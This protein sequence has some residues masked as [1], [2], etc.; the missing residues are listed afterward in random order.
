MISGAITCLLRLGLP[1]DRFG[2]TAALAV[3]H[4][5]AESAENNFAGLF[6][7]VFNSLDR[8]TFVLRSD[9]VDRPNRDDLR[10]LARLREAASPRSGGGAV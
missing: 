10:V 8:G 2:S 5:Y 3:I 7:A 6:T 9:E 4:G 1:K